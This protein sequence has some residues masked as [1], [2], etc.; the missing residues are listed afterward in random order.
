MNLFKK[1]KK[2]FSLIEL[3]L[4]LG[5]IAAITISAFMIYKNVKSSNIA[6]EE[7]NNIH[8]IK[9]EIKSLYLSSPGYDGIKTDVLVK[10]KVF[11]EK[12]LISDNGTLKPINSFKGDITVV[13]AA[14]NPE[15]TNSYG[16]TLRYY[17]VPSEECIKI[18]TALQ[19]S[20]YRIIIQ[21][22]VGNSIFLTVDQIVKA[23]NSREK[24]TILFQDITKS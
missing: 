18:V 1:N 24:L 12:M 9:S 3:L 10:A 22:P 4:A 15:G 21:L 23:C 2:G 7:I 6:K 11:P 20:F 17:N 8:M 19:P 14:D 5:V 16:Y 13:G